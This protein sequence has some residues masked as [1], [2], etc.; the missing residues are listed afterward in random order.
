MGG[1]HAERP[2][3]GQAQ[4]PEAA[5]GGRGTRPAD[6][7]HMQWRA[8][9]W[10]ALNVAAT[11]DMQQSFIGQAAIKAPSPNEVDSH[12]AALQLLNQLFGALRCGAA[13]RR[14]YR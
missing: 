7:W 9:E 10:N 8:G 4:L 13:G 14:Q 6:N 3:N 5:A 2:R 12:A 11:G 1:R